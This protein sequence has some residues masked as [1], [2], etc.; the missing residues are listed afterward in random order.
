MQKL[1]KLQNN[2]HLLSCY[3][4]LESKEPPLLKKKNSYQRNKKHRG[5]V[6]VTRMVKIK[7]FI[8]WFYYD[9]LIL[10]KKCETHKNSDKAL[11]FSRKQVFC[12]RNLKPC[13]TLKFTNLHNWKLGEIGILRSLKLNELKRQCY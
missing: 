2:L 11:L 3:L 9:L 10:I 13:T 8:S 7:L 4:F 5:R 6:R 1:Q 12:M